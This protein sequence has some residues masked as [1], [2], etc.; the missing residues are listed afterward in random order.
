M[1]KFTLA[2]LIKIIPPAIKNIYYTRQPFIITLN[3]DDDNKYT[4]SF[5]NQ[6]FNDIHYTYEFGSI[7]INDGNINTFDKLINCV[8]NLDYPNPGS[9]SSILY[10]D[11]TEDDTFVL[12]VGS[13]NPNS[14]PLYISEEFDINGNT[15]DSSH[16]VFPLGKENNDN[17][18]YKI[19]FKPFGVTDSESIKIKI[20]YWF[21]EYIY[22]FNFTPA[23]FTEL[24]ENLIN[25]RTKSW[26]YDRN[27]NYPIYYDFG[28]QYDDDFVYV[29]QNNYYIVNNHSYFTNFKSTEPAVLN[30]DLS[31]YKFFDESGLL[32][33]TKQ[34]TFQK[35]YTWYPLH[36]Q[37]IG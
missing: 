35:C 8:Y 16:K 27:T 15:I 19:N 24:P 26:P 17:L 6:Y 14:D 4:D 5:S 2:H 18:F 22:Y 3:F 7:S 30:K 21:P 12:K 36:F 20:S 9:G 33:Q 37:G 25:E 13:D 34:Y 1:K 11:K 29:N 23:Y 31:E 10:C 32:D 28:G